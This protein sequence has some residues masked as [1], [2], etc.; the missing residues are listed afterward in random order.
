MACIERGEIA[1]ANLIDD[2]RYRHRSPSRGEDGR[3]MA[4]LWRHDASTHRAES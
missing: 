2:R 4:E 1:R 3:A